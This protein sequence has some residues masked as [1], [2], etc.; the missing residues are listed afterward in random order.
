MRVKTTNPFTYSQTLYLP[1]LLVCLETVS[2]WWWT[3]LVRITRD[4]DADTANNGTA[5]E[6]TTS[7]YVTSTTTDPVTTTG[8]P[9][10]PSLTPDAIANIVLSGVAIVFL[11]TVL[12][13]LMATFNQM[14]H[15]TRVKT[16]LQRNQQID[17][18]IAAA[19]TRQKFDI[20]EQQVLNRDGLKVQVDTVGGEGGGRSLDL[21]AP[22]A[23]RMSSEVQKAA[24][25]V[26]SHEGVITEGTNE[27]SKSNSDVVVDLG[28]KASGSSGSVDDDDKPL[29][30]VIAS[31]SSDAE[32]N[33]AN[34]QPVLLVQPV[35]PEE[36]V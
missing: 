2:G 34:Q 20:K 17:R 8:A 7:T 12:C 1:V 6:T 32:E 26:S 21:V 27:T 29:I 14:E 33:P 24:Q 5:N 10:T 3:D 25:E 4:L 16:A 15:R 28:D 30:S 13:Y 22:T 31:V 18:Q 11:T 35:Q 19:R 23:A 9:P 36:L